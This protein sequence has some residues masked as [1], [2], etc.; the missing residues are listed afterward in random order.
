MFTEFFTLSETT[1]CLSEFTSRISNPF[2]FL[3][4]AENEQHLILHL[5]QFT[6]HLYFQYV[7][8]GAMY[9]GK[10]AD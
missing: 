2:H 1:S 9:W 5:I 3:W 8:H 10:K 7:S 6:K 4:F